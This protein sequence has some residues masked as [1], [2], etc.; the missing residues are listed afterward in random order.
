MLLHIEDFEGM[1]CDCGCGGK[2]EF[3]EM[4]NTCGECEKE[5]V[6][7]MIDVN[8]CALV[9]VCPTCGIQSAI[10]IASKD[11]YIELDENSLEEGI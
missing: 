11:A 1:E 6:V 8:Q 4:S 5:E 7:I 2:A 10:A 3:L 9:R